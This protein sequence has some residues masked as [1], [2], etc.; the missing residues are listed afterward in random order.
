[1]RGTRKAMWLMAVALALAATACSDD[2]DDPTGPAP[3][4][5]RGTWIGTAY[6]G[7]AGVPQPIT[8][9]ID[10]DGAT[11][12]GVVATENVPDGPI[13]NGVWN[14]TA[15]TWETREGS[16]TARWSATLS[17]GDLV[18]SLVTGELSFQATR[19]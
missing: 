2:D 19:H 15:A 16:Q 18:G 6:F 17:A 3:S 1:M 11:F 8:I 7:I 14:G 12:G 4:G 13:L 10:S 9:V 5:L